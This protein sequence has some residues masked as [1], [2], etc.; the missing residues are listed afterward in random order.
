[1]LAR[2][3]RVLLAST[4]SPISFFTMID[5]TAPTF[6]GGSGGIPA[7]EPVAQRPINTHGTHTIMMHN[8]CAITVSLKLRALFA[9]SQCWNR[10][11]NMPTLSG[12]NM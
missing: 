3:F 5:N 8:G 9:V 6:S 1:M 4:G 11:G 10:C 7:S 12:M 2:S